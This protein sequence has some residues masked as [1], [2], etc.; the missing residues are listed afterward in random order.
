MLKIVRKPDQIDI[1]DLTDV[2]EES[3]RAD[4]KRRYPYL[5]TEEQQTVAERDFSAYFDYFFQE[6][7]AVYYLWIIEGRYV[8]A[9]R[10]ERYAD[11]VLLTGLETAP[12]ERRKGY[13]REL[14]LAVIQEESTVPIFSHVSRKDRTSFHLHLSCGFAVQQEYARLLDGTVTTQYCT[15]VYKGKGKI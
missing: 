15:L 5:C 1:C 10:S 4:G 2:Y 7:G 12:G 13:A 9:V 11:G 14:L 3:I 6:Q 8:A